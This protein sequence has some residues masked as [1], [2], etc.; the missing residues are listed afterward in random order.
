MTVSKG[1]PYV[2]T[3]ATDLIGKVVGNGDYDCGSTTDEIVG[4][5]EV[6]NGNI[7]TVATN[8]DDVNKVA[9]AIDRGDLETAVNAVETT[10][11]NVR[12]S[13]AAQ[14]SAEAA[15]CVRARGASRCRGK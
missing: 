5:I 13:Q 8:I 4:D 12:L 7:H 1:M 10:T 9:D 11:E 14:K 2:E 6:V 15:E 3:V